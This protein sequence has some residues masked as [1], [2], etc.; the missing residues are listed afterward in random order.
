MAKGGGAALAVALVLCLGVL[1]KA[2]HAAETVVA[3]TFDDNRTSQLQVLP[4]LERHGL[5]ATFNIITG[6]VGASGYMSWDDL[7]AVAA[8]GHEIAG[9]TVSH[10]DLTAISLE[11]ARREICEGR[12]ALVAHGHSPETFCYPF[13]RTSPEV[14]ALVAEC[15]YAAAQ[16]AAGLGCATCPAAESLP[17]LN[18]F[19]I[20]GLSSSQITETL[21]DLQAQVIRAE[22]AGG[23]L[24]VFKFHQIC[25]GDCGTYTTHPD[26][27]DAFFGWLAVRAGQGTVVKTLASA[28]R[29]AGEEPPPPATQERPIVW[30]DFWRY[31]DDGT[32]PGSGWNVAAYDD[33]G[34]A[35][36]RGELGYGELDEATTLQR[37]DPSQTSVYF[38]KRIVLDQVPDRAFLEVIYD[39]GLAVWVNGSLIFA[40]NVDR[41]LEHRF[42][43]SAS[44]DNA[45]ERAEIPPGAFVAGE[46]QIAVVVKQVGRTSPDLSFDLQLEMAFPSSPPDPALFVR[47]P[48][49]GE[50][51]LAGEAIDVAWDASV[52]VAFV[53]IDFSADGG[54][55]WTPIATRLVNRSPYRWTLPEITTE[56]ALVRVRDAEGVARED[57]SDAPFAIAPPP[58]GITEQIP[59]GSTWRYHDDG[60]DPGAGWAGLAYDDGAWP[61]GA[62][63]LG[64]GDGDEATVLQQPKRTALSVYFR[65][66]FLVGE[67]ITA[68]DLQVLFDDGIAV[69]VNGTLVFSRNITRFEHNRSASASAENEVAA[70]SIA[71]DP[72]P[73]VSGE[74]VIA[75]M[76][77]QV[78]K[79]SP[80]LSF[81]LDL[82]LTTA[83]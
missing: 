83:P 64:Y 45:F 13:S 55:S 12:E 29:E 25:T 70:A 67:R 38:R 4:L 51:F 23:G 16:V 48:N 21:A 9:H 44:T 74:N 68:A 63:E 73:F 78:G 11:E 52:P 81:D 39:D 75:V 79:S 41:G 27:L 61:L 36:G 77:K 59:F 30:G 32:D 1:P 54:A 53:D 56:A 10:P 18:P 57:V 14:Q 2:A 76:V 3:L 62:A 42:Y 43:A 50:Q 60:S 71:L 72:Y 31:H 46:N 7:A 24:V 15:G 19:R 28:L 69:Y 8:A 33:R 5:H 35:E 22:E 40:R 47:A 6:R 37:T 82:Q 26:T 49:G 58:S 65:R 20:R 80:D 34:W 66:T 17:P